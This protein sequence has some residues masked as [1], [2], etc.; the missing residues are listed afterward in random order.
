MLTCGGSVY[1]G[2]TFKGRRPRVLFSSDGRTWSAPQPILSEGDW[3]WRVTWHDGVAYGADYKSGGRRPEDPDWELAI[4]QSRDGLNWDLLKKLDVPGRPNETTLRFAPDGEMIAL[5]RREGGDTMGWVGRSKPPYTEWKWS[6]SNYRFGGPNLL[7]LP[8]GTWL[9]GTR[10]YT[11]IKP[12]TSV[13]ARTILAQLEPNGHLT[14]LATLPSG[15]DNSYPGMVW[16]HGVL[17]M[18]YYSSHEGKTAIYC[19][20]IKITER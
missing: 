13:G 5:V 18:T 6:E 8:S 1:Q 10:D 3:M 4:F 7:Q 14:P 17:W 11:Q 16:D 12:G 2:K 19:A 15:G 9:V 20:K